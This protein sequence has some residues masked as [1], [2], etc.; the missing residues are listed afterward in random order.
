MPS[1]K[2]LYY[3]PLNLIKQVLRTCQNPEERLE[4]VYESHDF[5][6]ARVLRVNPSAFANDV[7]V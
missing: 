6:L 1:L 4:D 2:T 3:L 7:T 5:L